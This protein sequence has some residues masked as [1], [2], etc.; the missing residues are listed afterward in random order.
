M[1]GRSGEFAVEIST[2]ARLIAS[3]PYQE[4]RIFQLQLGTRDPA[5]LNSRRIAGPLSQFINFNQTYS[6]STILPRKNSGILPGG[7]GHNHSRLKVIRRCK[8]CCLNSRLLRIFPIIVTFYDHA[9]LVHQSYYRV[10]QSP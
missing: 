5:E 8:P 3:N 2:F 7:D 4:A 6:R 1:A 10:G 9:V